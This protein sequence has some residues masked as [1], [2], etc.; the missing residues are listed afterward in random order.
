MTEKMCEKLRNKEVLVF[1][2]IPGYQ[3]ELKTRIMDHE[4]TDNKVTLYGTHSTN[5]T[6]DVNE[7]SEEDSEWDYTINGTM[8]IAIV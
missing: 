7:I 4:Y 6:F 2:D 5:L 8:Y 1:F 3:F